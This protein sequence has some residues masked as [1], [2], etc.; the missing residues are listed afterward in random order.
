MRKSV[1]FIFLFF[2]AFC[3]AQKEFHVFPID[4]SQIKGSPNG[5][6]SLNNPWDLQT[7]L[8]QSSE[9]VNGGDIIWL[10]KGIYNGRYKSKLKSTNKK[11]I[12]VSGF[13]NDLVILNGNIQSS[14][15]QVLE[16]KGDKVIFK[17][18]EVTFLGDYSRNESDRNFK[19]CTGIYHLSGVAKFQNLRIYNNPG[20]GI[21]SW[22]LTGESII[23][24]CTIYNNGYQGKRG[25]GVGI[26]VQNEDEKFRIIRNNIIFNN[27]YK[28]IEVW[29]ATS[30]TNK[31]F[32]KNVSF[33]N[34]I[35][36]NNGSPSGRPWDNLIIASGDA[37]GINVA[38]NVKVNNNV[39]YHNTD[40]ND[41]KNFGHGSSITLGYISKALVENI[42][43]LDNII[44]GRNNALNLL[45]IKSAELRNNIVYSGYVHFK[46][47]S[48][49]ALEAKK[50]NLNHNVYYTRKNS[51]FRIL[52][53]KDY[54]LS[55]WQ[56]TFDVDKE[57][58]WKLLKDFEIKPVLKIQKLS[59]KPNEFNVALLEKNGNDVT[60]DFSNHD[61][62]KGSS[63]KIYDVE[64]RN[65]VVK[66][67]AISK[68]KKITF[69]MGLKAFEK[70]LHNTIAIK[71][72]DNFGVYRIV[73]EEKK[74]KR[75]VFKQLF[76]WLF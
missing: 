26:Y 36:F 72:V 76:G 4:D 73:F 46:K 70:P 3:F 39:F 6:G 40:F 69:P 67:G 33:V 38:K 23:E 37:K 25:H 75:N 53:H 48:F 11:Y 10:H 9:R 16:I 62:E 65:K 41:F 66:S 34:N 24:D 29:S 71:S 54:T 68:D 45:H 51:G 22:K 5:D 17:N 58:E 42:S 32:V 56:N 8:S 20:S 27:Y 31:E 49:K 35:V 60:V 19:S 15:K 63:F 7:A 14:V 43:I 55:E 28:G 61:I 64:N 18:F 52:K 44:I 2:V 1:S 59:S 13:G 50:I 74:Q 57:S 30:V 12:S 21:G 47:S